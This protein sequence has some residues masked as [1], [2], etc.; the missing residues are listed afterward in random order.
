MELREKLVAQLPFHP[1]QRHHQF[2]VGLAIHPGRIGGRGGD[3][4][5][6]VAHA[7]DR[8]AL[9]AADSGIYLHGSIRETSDEFAR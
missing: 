3:F 5:A 1:R 2:D 9:L 4:A 6:S 8:S 7:A